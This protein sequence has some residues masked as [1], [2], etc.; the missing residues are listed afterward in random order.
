MRHEARTCRTT[1]RSTG[2]I[3]RRRETRRRRGPRPNPPGLGRRGGGEEARWGAR[4][5]RERDRWSTIHYAHPRALSALLGCLT[6]RI[7]ARSAA[8]CAHLR[9]P[10]R[11]LWVKVLL[12]QQVLKEL[13][14]KLH[15]F[16]LDQRVCIRSTAALGQP[17]AHHLD[18]GLPALVEFVGDQV[19]A[20]QALADGIPVRKCG[21]QSA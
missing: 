1:Q 10:V 3:H 17:P 4:R 21:T 16:A 11:F 8:A 15:V 12:G 19:V 2:G 9:L 18:D 5:V 7:R 6:V 14:V 20:A 13:P